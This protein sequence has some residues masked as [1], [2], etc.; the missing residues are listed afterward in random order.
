MFR[1]FLGERSG[2]TAIEYA[3]IAGLIAMAIVVGAR[4]TGTALQ[5]TMDNVATQVTEAGG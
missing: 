4:Q 3:L 5:E 1:Q 2:A